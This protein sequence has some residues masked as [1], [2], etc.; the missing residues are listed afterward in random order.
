MLIRQGKAFPLTSES[1]NEFT[2]RF[3]SLTEQKDS[4]KQEQKPVISETPQPEE[5]QSQ[6]VKSNILKNSDQ[7]VDTYLETLADEVSPYQ[8]NYNDN[9]NLIDGDMEVTYGQDI[10]NADTGIDE[11]PITAENTDSIKTGTKP[12]TKNPS[13]KNTNQTEIDF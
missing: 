1:L 2:N 7:P 11:H 3:F 8:D 4:V 13:K 12:K 6:E 5:T 9:P 10:E